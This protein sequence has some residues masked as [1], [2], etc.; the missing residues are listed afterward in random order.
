MDQFETMPFGCVGCSEGQRSQSRGGRSDQ[1][2][3]EVKDISA[4]SYL[5]GSVKAGQ[6]HNRS[7]AVCLD[8]AQIVACAQ[9]PLHASVSKMQ[10]RLARIY[11]RPPGASSSRQI[12]VGAET[13]DETPGLGND[14]AHQ[15]V[16]FGFAVSTA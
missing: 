9:E 5:A 14:K 2:V 12:T 3:K 16:C 13:G 8:N 7:T 10:G 1:T 6:P 4:Q 15:P 11:T